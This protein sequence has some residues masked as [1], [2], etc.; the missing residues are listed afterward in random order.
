MAVFIFKQKE[1]ITLVATTIITILEF[2]LKFNK[3]EEK[4][5]TI[6]E[7]TRF[8]TMHNELY[9]SGL[10]S[11]NC[12]DLDKKYLETMIKLI[13]DVDLKTSNEF[14]YKSGNTVK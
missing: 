9:R 1:L 10:K 5:K 12:D 7:A 8:I 13:H 4:L 6:D 2:Y 11:Y 3:Y 14:N